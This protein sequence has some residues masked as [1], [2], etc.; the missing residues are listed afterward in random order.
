MRAGPDCKLPL[1]NALLGKLWNNT[2]AELN[3]AS[4]ADAA[5]AQ[6]A[7][8][9][10]VHAAFTL[11]GPSLVRATRRSLLG[12][13]RR[14]LKHMQD[15]PPRITALMRVSLLISVRLWRGLLR[16]LDPPRCPHWTHRRPGDRQRQRSRQPRPAT[17]WAASP[18]PPHRRRASL[19]HWAQ[20][21]KRRC[22]CHLSS[23]AQALKTDTAAPS[24]VVAGQL[25][26]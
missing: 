22:H 25:L 3:T 7:Q 23:A 13:A 16:R 21:C 10:S 17:A 5:A 2:L 12:R 8:T 18:P 19:A 4:V 14:T 20:R 1:C 9:L 26:T 6:A 24:K 15:W 11:A